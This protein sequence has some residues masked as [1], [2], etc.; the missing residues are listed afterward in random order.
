MPSF[1]SWAASAGLLLAAT[2]PA[3]ALVVDS[4]VYDNSP[5]WTVIVFGGTSMSSNGSSTVLSTAQG[6]GVWFGNGSNYGDTPAWSLG[7]SSSGNYLSL[8]ASF[9]S[10]SAD[11]SAYL[12]DGNHEAAWQFNPT[13]CANDCYG[14]PALSGVQFLYGDSSDPSIARQGF[15]ALD[16]TQQH[17]FDW[18][19]KNGQ[20]SY[21]IDGQVVFSGAAYALSYGSGLLV[22]GDGSGSTQSGVGAMTVYS[23]LVDT[24]PAA[25]SLVP[26][27][28]SWAL[29][30]GGV[31]TL[32]ARGRRRRA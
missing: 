19:L 17:Q 25:I 10:G 3:Q 31:A 11:W 29:M 14:L 21:R 23:S 9:S 6:R 20:V 28:A 30:L 15:V 2:L 13:N 22:I 4:L 1:A 24:A 7:N 32:L 5:D 18:L 27:P 26:E 16:L 12:L 8:R